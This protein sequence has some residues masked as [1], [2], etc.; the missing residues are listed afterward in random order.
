MKKLGFPDIFIKKETIA[1]LF[2][3]TFIFAFA[4][5]WLNQSLCFQNV[6]NSFTVNSGL[7]DSFCEKI[8]YSNPVRQPIN[9]FSNIIYLIVAVIIF[10]NVKKDTNSDSDK[11]NRFYESFLGLLLICIFIFSVFFH[12]V[13][14]VRSHK[15]DLTAV[16]AFV[17]FPPIYLFYHFIFKKKDKSVYV[18]KVLFSLSFF[19]IFLLLYS[20]THN[21]KHNMIIL[22]LILLF[23]ILSFL[24]FNKKPANLKYLIYSLVSVVT[25]M[26]WYELDRFKFFCN[27]EGLFQL[28]SLWHI[29]TGLSAFYFYIFIRNNKTIITQN[30]NTL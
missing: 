23:F 29:F 14:S 2:A 22:S 11:M 27:P 20:T 26:I 8:F 6:W 19:I 18:S 24:V 9:T 17:L 25:A 28:H 10:K 7:E 15:L 30:F 16:C 3:V 5:W 21:E 12:A 13:L 1:L 4:I